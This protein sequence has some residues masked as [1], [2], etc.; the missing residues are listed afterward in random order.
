MT[1]DTL[2]QDIDGCQY[3]GVKKTLPVLECCSVTEAPLSRRDAEKAAAV[4]KAIA[5]PARLRLLSLIAAQ[6]DRE[7]CTCDLIT[8]L[9]LTQPTVTHHLRVLT[10]AGLLDR[11]RRGTWTYYRVVP[12]GLKSIRDILT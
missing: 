11:E 7:A 6:P 10:Q 4:L 8:P 12:A 1:I 3:A 5:D 9:G 2:T